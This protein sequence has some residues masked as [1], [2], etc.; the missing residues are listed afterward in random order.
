MLLDPTDPFHT[1]GAFKIRVMTF[2]NYVKFSD[3]LI[4]RV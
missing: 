4:V 1:F 2:L 3:L